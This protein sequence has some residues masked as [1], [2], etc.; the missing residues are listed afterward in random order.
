MR[1]LITGATGFFGSHIV[2]TIYKNYFSKDNIALLIRNQKR[3]IEL[4]GELQ[5]IQYFDLLNTNYKEQ[6]KDFKPDLVVHL[7]SY[8]TSQDDEENINK[9]LDVNIEMGTH[10]LDAL[11][12]TGI[13]YFINVG[14]C[15]EYYYNDGELRS[16]YLYSAT[17]TAFRAILRYY[18]QILNFQWINVI[19]YTVYGE[20]DSQKKV[21]DYIISSLDSKNKI[22]MTAGEQKLDFI[23]IEDV[24]DFFITL[25]NKIEN[26]K[27]DFIELH[28][29]TGKGTSIR[30]LAHVIETTYSRSTNIE[31]GALP[32]RQNDIMQSVAHIAKNK[33]V[34][35]WEAKIGL[36]KGIQKIKKDC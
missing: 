31:W 26:I 30:E 7:A 1:I 19:P 5:N 24:V 4:F 34:L 33:E 11:K 29:G 27:Q 2:P 18:Q 28:L 12:G 10:L 32:Y 8:L 25:I 35:N 17:K 20:G 16:A 15:A 23:H 14:T 6:I 21:I 9:I 36:E 3:A 13:K 22:P